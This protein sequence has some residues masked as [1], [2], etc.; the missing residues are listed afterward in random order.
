MEKSGIVVVSKG[1]KNYKKIIS[2]L[3]E[4]ARADVL[5]VDTIG[6]ALDVIYSAEADVLITDLGGKEKRISAPVPRPYYSSAGDARNNINF[7]V[8]YINTHCQERLNL[9]DMAAMIGVTSNYL[10]RLFRQEKGI[11]IGRYIEHVRLK[12]AAQE[13]LDTDRFVQDISVSY[14]YRNDSYFCKVFKKEF[15][16]TPAEYREKMRRK[17][18]TEEEEP[19][20]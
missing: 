14:G 3:D 4:R 20:T 8:W 18:E 16:L 12:K 15:G 6:E 2:Y 11:T 19:A 10:C 13:L 7:L 1:G 5:R 9:K 17:D